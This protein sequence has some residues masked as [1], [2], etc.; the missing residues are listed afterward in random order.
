MDTLETTCWADPLNR[1]E[2]RHLAERLA[3]ACKRSYDASRFVVAR[4]PQP[5][6]IEMMRALTMI[7]MDCSNL[8]TDVTERAAR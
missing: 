2:R 7:S 5:A 1:A 6:D 8:F 4:D 3:R